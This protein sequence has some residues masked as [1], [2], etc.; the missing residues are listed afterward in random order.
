MMI[1]PGKLRHKLTFQHLS[2]SPDDKCEQIETWTD[3]ITVHC[4]VSQFTGSEKVQARQEITD[5]DVT[6]TVR[7]SP[8]I[9]DIN[10][11]DY[12]IVFK[13][14]VYNITFIDDPYLSHER[15]VISAKKFENAVLPD[16]DT[17]SDDEEVQDDGI[18]QP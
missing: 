13:G 2:V 15:F 9:A 8:T 11:Q 5:S 4:S 1:D 3:L 17:E 14:V 16:E 18:Q 7:Y 6:F 12:R 10:E